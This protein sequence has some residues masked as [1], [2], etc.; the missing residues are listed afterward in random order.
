MRA[1]CIE[2]LRLIVCEVF[3]D[4]VAVSE[5]FV[6]V[7]TNGAEVAA[8]GSLSAGT[9]T[10]VLLE[11]H[12][13]DRAVVLQLVSEVFFVCAREWWLLVHG[14]QLRKIAAFKVGLITVGSMVLKIIEFFLV[15]FYGFLFYY[16]FIRPGF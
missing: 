11:L 10:K 16:R 6:E 9:L 15:R 14:G 4:H 12:A 13:A 1:A 2:S 3:V 7:S 8:T 5:V